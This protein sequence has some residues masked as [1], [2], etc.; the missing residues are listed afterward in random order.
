MLIYL[1]SLVE[2]KIHIEVTGIEVVS[3]IIFTDRFKVKYLF[4][5]P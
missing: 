1:K 3:F 2:V 4:L 5:P